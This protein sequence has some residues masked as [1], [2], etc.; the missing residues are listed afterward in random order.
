LPKYIF[1]CWANKNVYNFTSVISVR[2]GAA[3]TAGN[4]YNSL[5]ININITMSV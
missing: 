3:T 1:F 4:K 2:K 5:A